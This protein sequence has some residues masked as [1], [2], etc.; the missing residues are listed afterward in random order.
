MAEALEA[1]HEKGVIHRDLKPANIKVTP[2]GKVKVL[3]FGLAKAF[4]GDGADANLSQSPTLSLAATQQGVILGTAAYMSPEQARGESADRKADIWAFGTVLFEMLSGQGTFDG[5]TVSDVLA[6]VLRAD[7][8]WRDLPLDLHPRIR[9]LLERCLE[10]EAG[11]RCHDIADVRVDIQKVLADPR[12]V[13]LP[14]EAAA[15]PQVT[16][17]IVLPWAVGV[18][19]IT[20]ILAGLLGWNL[21]P[22][23]TSGVGPVVRFPLLLPEGQAFHSTNHA[24]L[25]VSP[26]GADLV[27]SADD[28]LYLRSM[29]ELLPRPI[30]GTTGERPS[31]PFISP[32]G[33]WVGY[34]S[35]FLLKKIPIAGG[36]PEIIVDP[37]LGVVFGASWGPDENIVFG[38]LDGVWSVP[39]GGGTL[40][41]LI[42]TEP[43]EQVFG[44]ALLPDGEHLLF[45]LTEAEGPT[46][47]DQADIV[48]QSLETESRKTLVSGA[49]DARYLPTGHLTYAKGDTLYAVPFDL[50]R[51]E[52]TGDEVAVLRGLQR[53][54]QPTIRSGSAN[55]G[56][57]R[58]GTLV[59]LAAGLVT[60]QYHVVVLV[61]RHGTEDRLDLP[62]ADY[63]SPRLSPSARRLA[64]TRRRAD[65]RDETLVYDLSDT[66]LQPLLIEGG[67]FVWTSDERLAFTS[68]RDGSRRVYVKEIDAL[69]DAVPLTTPEAGTRHVAE[70]WSPDDVLA[71]VVAGLGELGIHT[72]SPGQPPEVFVDVPGTR[73]QGSTFSPDGRHLAYVSDETDGNQVYVKPFPRGPVRRVTTGGGLAPAWSR[74]GAELIY[75]EVLQG[76]ETSDEWLTVVSVATE[77]TLRFGRPTAL[78]ARTRPGRPWVRHYDIATDGRFIVVRPELSTESD[79]DRP[80]MTVVV[81]WF[82]ELKERVPVP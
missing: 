23:T 41:L 4:T 62:P 47:W 33:Q 19:A 20:V 35:D 8:D 11:D 68:D 80:R 3:D 76:G 66:S 49:S 2:E 53:A 14:Q 42:G 79:Q 37:G 61:D 13:L 69:E 17:R 43:G 25:S 67:E 70:A 78:P 57:T 10:K 15:E 24:V 74:D 51:L 63:R 58:H 6:A 71:F 64:V 59:Y 21:R 52:V 56:F 38:Q 39:A 55:Y 9:L 30:Q 31:S 32:D 48:V 50:D 73:Q 26:T 46:R 82:E 22:E 16:W 81:N 54:T 40:Q 29:D 18:F 36:V 72:L 5:R 65:G 75:Q 60:A 45:S 28:Q 1:A 7:P 27:Y 12:G 34:C 77:P 44:P